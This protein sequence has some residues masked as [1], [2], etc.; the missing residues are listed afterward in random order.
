M[1]S[2]SSTRFHLF[3]PHGNIYSI[4][5]CHFFA[6]TLSIQIHR[7]KSKSCAIKN[8]NFSS[9]SPSRRRLYIPHDSFWLGISLIVCNSF[10]LFYYIHLY[11]FSISTCL[12]IFAPFFHFLYIFLGLLRI[13]LHTL[14]TMLRN[15]KKSFLNVWKQTRLPVKL[16]LMEKACINEWMKDIEHFRNGKCQS[17]SDFSSFDNFRFD[18][19]FPRL[20]CTAVFFS[21]C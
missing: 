10:I 2:H 16:E 4:Q 12:F 14:F 5:Y 7:T 17:V 3:M 13:C 18:I 20:F 9:P 11:D 8:Q 19:S 6:K 15:K 21:C 1:Q